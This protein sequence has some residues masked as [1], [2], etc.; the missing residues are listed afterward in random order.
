M[1]W[2]SAPDSSKWVAKQCLLCLE[3]HRRHYVPCLTMSRNGELLRNLP[4]EIRSPPAKPA[5]M[6]RHSFLLAADSSGR[7]GVSPQ[8]YSDPRR[9][10]GEDVF[11]KTLSFMAIVASR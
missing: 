9:R 4:G 6:T 10:C 3:R 1:V 8:V 5:D 11:V 2:R 7:R